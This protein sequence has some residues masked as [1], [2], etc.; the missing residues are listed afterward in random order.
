M[1]GIMAELLDLDRVGIHDNFFEL[2]GHS[3]L[4]TQFIAR[5]NRVFGRALPLRVLFEHPSVAALAEHLID[6][7]VDGV[8]GDVLARIMDEVDGLS[9]H[10]I[11]ELLG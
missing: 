7:Q 11:S 1:A 9:D 10:E 6:E 3:L 8:D 4:A 2:G 5:V